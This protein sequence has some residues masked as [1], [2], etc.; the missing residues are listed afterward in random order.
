MEPHEYEK[1]QP[2]TERE[3]PRDLGKDR[4]QIGM[5][6]VALSCIFLISLIVQI[7]FYMLLTAFAPQWADTAWCQLLISS[8]AMYAVAM[9]LSLLFYRT[10]PAKAPQKRE[11]SPAVFFG[12]LA[13]CFCLT[14]AGNII[15]SAVNAVIGAI[16]GEVPVN[17]LAEMTASIPLP[18]TFLSVGVLAPVL[19]EIFFRKL[20][21]DRLRGYGELPAVLIS[22]IAFGLVH[23]NFYQFFYAAGIGMLLGYV[24]LRTGNVLHTIGLHMCIN[25]VGGVYTTAMLK[26]LDALLAAEE[27]TLP[28]LAASLGGIAMMLAYLAFMAAVLIGSIVAIALLWRRVRFHRA[29]QPLNARQWVRVLLLNPAVW[30]FAGVAILL[31]LI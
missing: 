13:I 18:L 12:L 1:M 23:G 29:E 2:L 4:L 27:V 20:M 19:E 6:L 28:I 16:T 30:I 10:V 15:G 22:G 24:Y 7:L 14:Y 17:D 8:G 25:M 21:L 31:F 5:P 26:K 9:P 11:L 3:M